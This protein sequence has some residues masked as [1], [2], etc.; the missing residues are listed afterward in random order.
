M[1]AS[2][3]RR[4]GALDPRLD[5]EAPRRARSTIA[6][7]HPLLADK[8]NAD[9]FETAIATLDAGRYDAR[10][11]VPEHLASRLAAAL[12]DLGRS[13]EALTLARRTG[14][15]QLE[16]EVLVRL[17]RLD[18]ALAAA[19]GL[20]AH[21]A[22]AVLRHTA[23][24]HGALAANDLGRKLSRRRSATGADEDGYASA[25]FA[26][27]LRDTALQAGD[28]AFARGRPSTPPPRPARGV[29]RHD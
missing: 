20:D 28:V 3:R 9:A 15:R 14:D 24:I 12:A 23:R 8:G 1:R 2:P 19:G 13:E 17:A 22:A 26:R 18:E 7:R 10:G 4:F 21:A 16:A 5:E 25:S 11:A 27:T 6:A 29:G